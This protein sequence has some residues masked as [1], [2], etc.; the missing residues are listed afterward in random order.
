MHFIVHLSDILVINLLHQ[1]TQVLKS[2]SLSLK[3]VEI[4]KKAIK[5]IQNVM[6]IVVLVCWMFK[7]VIPHF[8]CFWI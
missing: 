1:Y 7:V 4:I 8:K 5:R 2:P 6:Q 3:A